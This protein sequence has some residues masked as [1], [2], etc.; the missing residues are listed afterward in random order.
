M[1]ARALLGEMKGL[2][3]SDAVLDE[4]GY[5]Y[6]TVP[7]TVPDRKGPVIGFIAHMDVVDVVPWENIRPRIV[8]NYDGGDV[9]LNEEKNIVL[10]PTDYP[11]LLHVYRGFQHPGG[12]D[13]AFLHSLYDRRPAHRFLSAP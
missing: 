3:I 10:S 5:V 9:L 13:H 2:G 1:F 6:G 8:R 11:D 4:N 12:T 7:A